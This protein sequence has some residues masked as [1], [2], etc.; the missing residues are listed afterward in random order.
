MWPLRKLLLTRGWVSSGQTL[1]WRAGKNTC[2]FR[3]K[4]K[5]KSFLCSIK[6]LK[7]SFMGS[8]SPV[9]ASV[10]G[11]TDVGCLKKMRGRC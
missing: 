7:V 3:A 4:I 11:K 1:Q 9:E 5:K 2:E 8:E 10:I 6:T